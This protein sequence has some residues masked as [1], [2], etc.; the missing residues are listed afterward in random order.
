AFTRAAEASPALRDMFLASLFWIHIDHGRT[1]AAAGIADAF[2][3]RHPG[4]RLV[5]EMRA[6]A[7]YR[8][9]RLPEARGE[10]EAL[11]AE[12][13][14]LPR[15]DAV[16]PL[17]YYRSVGNLARLHA[18]RGDRAA[19]DSLLTAWRRAEEAGLTPWLPSALK[20]DLARP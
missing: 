10:Y 13:A 18:A 14:G 1:T 8:A 5:R 17:G 7:L 12:Y 11:R 6:A 19:A 9:G 3:K 4:N 20:R 15:G 16:L 2:L